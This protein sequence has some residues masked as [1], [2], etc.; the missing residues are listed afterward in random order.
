VLLALANKMALTIW[1]ILVHRRQYQKGYGKALSPAAAMYLVTRE[2]TAQGCTDSKSCD[3]ETD[4][5]V[6]E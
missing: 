1:A 2:W 5:T 3:G 4:R 6:R